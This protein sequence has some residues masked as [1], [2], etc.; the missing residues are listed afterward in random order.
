MALI[1]HHK[2]FEQLSSVGIL[3][4]IIQHDIKDSIL[5]ADVAI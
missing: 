3:L 2:Y 1:S 5:S 4:I